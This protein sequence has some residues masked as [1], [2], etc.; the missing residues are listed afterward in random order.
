FG[1]GFG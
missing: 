1:T